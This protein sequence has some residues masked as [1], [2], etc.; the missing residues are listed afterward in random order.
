[1]KREKSCAQ[2]IENVKALKI[3]TNTALVLLKVQKRDFKVKRNFT[4][5][6]EK[7]TYK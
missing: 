3:A 4:K 2:K 7:P 6:G 1:M 5:G